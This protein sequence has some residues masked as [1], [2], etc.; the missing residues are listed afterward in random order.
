M[1]LPFDP[2]TLWLIGGVFG[3]LALA[4]GIGFVLGRRAAA[5]GTTDAARAT[6]SNLNAR[7]RAWWVI[8]SVC[9]A[10]LLLGPIGAS[11]LFGLASFWALREFLTLTPTSP[12]DHRA[13]FWVFFI[14]TP[15]Q[16]YLVATDGTGFS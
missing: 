15:L 2:Q 12:G 13:L 1:P 16:Y 10:A 3:F 5:P 14:I 6:I 4:S 9:A 7:L 11:V 8:I